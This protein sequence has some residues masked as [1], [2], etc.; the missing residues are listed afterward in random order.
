VQNIIA[1]ACGGAIGSVLRY[2][3]SVLAYRF[4]EPS[5]PWGTIAVNL[6]GSFLIGF[7]WEMFALSDGVS[8]T[9]RI[10]VLVGIL[11]GFTTFSTYTFESGGYLR[12]GY[13][14]QALMNVVFSNVLGISFVFVGFIGRPIYFSDGPIG[15][16][17][18]GHRIIN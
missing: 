18:Y 12:D 17:C 13:I 11:G 9:V 8:S 1:I 15:E 6:I 3:V 10:F 2:V 5:L 7:F 14:S 4:T 16:W